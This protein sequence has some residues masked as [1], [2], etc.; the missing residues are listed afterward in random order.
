MSVMPM[1]CDTSACWLARGRFS[2]RVSPVAV[3]PWLEFAATNN[4]EAK[5]N[6]ESTFFCMKNRTLLV[7]I[8]SLLILWDE[9]SARDLDWIWVMSAGASYNDELRL[10]FFRKVSGVAQMYNVA[11]NVRLS[12]GQQMSIFKHKLCLLSASL[13]IALAIISPVCAADEWQPVR[14]EELQ[15]TSEAKAPGAPAI[16]LYRKV[17]RNDEESKEHNYARIKILTE[18]GLKYANVEIPFLKDFTIVN[19]IH[20][21]T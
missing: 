18:Q 3:C 16:F 19:D 13:T 7:R 21:R 8:V 12:S 4:P 14:P 17:D 6:K 2:I 20:A 9:P 11:L 5:T 10:V 1:R 15:M